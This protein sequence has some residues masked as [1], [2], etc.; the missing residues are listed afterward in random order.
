M[1]EAVTSRLKV[2]MTVVSRGTPVAPPAGV[3]DA[4]VSGTAVAGTL[5][6]QVYGLPSVAPSVASIEPASVAV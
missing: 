2:A 1:D 5:K 4:T 6:L 3:A